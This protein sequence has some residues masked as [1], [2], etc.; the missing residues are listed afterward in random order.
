MKQVKKLLV[1]LPLVALFVL[2]SLPVLAADPAEYLAKSV[3]VKVKYEGL[4]PKKNEDTLTYTIELKD[5]LPEAD[6]E[7]AGKKSIA[8]YPVIKDNLK[9]ILSKKDEKNGYGIDDATLSAAAAAIA[10]AIAEDGKW[11]APTLEAVK[12]TAAKKEDPDAGKIHVKAY[13]IFNG[14][15]VPDVLDTIELREGWKSPQAITRTYYECSSLPN[16]YLYAGFLT[17]GSEEDAVTIESM[18][19]NFDKNEVKEAFGKKGAQYITLVVPSH[20]EVETW[21]IF[22]VGT[23][24]RLIEKVRVP[25]PQW[26]ALQNASKFMDVNGIFKTRIQKI[27]EEG[28][29]FKGMEFFNGEK[30]IVGLLGAYDVFGRKRPNANTIHAEIYYDKAV[31]AAKE[32]PTEKKVDAAT[33]PQ[34][35]IQAP[36]AQAPVTAANTTTTTAPVNTLPV[37]GASDSIFL[38]LSSAAL[39]AVGILFFKKH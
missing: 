25:F 18:V 26:V 8:F 28:Y 24:D 3:D 36:A 39:M 21:H 37:T 15:Y 22:P 33:A 38:F 16:E 23:R 17:V 31:A 13:D 29:A 19:F 2:G 14:E 20:V 34:A 35:Q 30:R 10:Q 7:A 4:G 27:N 1:I 12:L 5:L 9:S 6:F 11:T 32:V